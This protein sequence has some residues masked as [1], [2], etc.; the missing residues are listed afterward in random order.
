MTESRTY[1]KNRAL[2]MVPANKTV[3]DIPAFPVNGLSAPKLG[4]V[5]QAYYMLITHSV[6]F[7]IT[8][9]VC[10]HH[11]NVGSRH[12]PVVHVRVTS[13]LKTMNK[14]RHPIVASFSFSVFSVKFYFSEFVFKRGKLKITY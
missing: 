4:A 8:L 2:L 13:K 1:Q 5:P 6:F 7:D 3:P 9:G 10:Q 11:H 12:L 14:K